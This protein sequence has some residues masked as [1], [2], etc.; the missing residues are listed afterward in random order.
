MCYASRLYQFCF[1]P[2]KMKSARE[3]IFSVSSGVENILLAHFSLNCMRYS[4]VFGRFSDFI[5]G[6]NFVFL[7]QNF[8]ILDFWKFAGKLCSFFSGNDFFFLGMDYF[9]FFWHNFVFSGSFQVF[10]SGRFKTSR[11]E[12]FNF[13]GR[14]FFTGKKILGSRKEICSI[15]KCRYE[16]LT[17][18]T[19]RPDCDF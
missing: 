6:W 19:I 15:V 16:K 13:S 2:E 11:A 1:L 18:E 17:L 3:T 8:R 4:E 9:F 5:L 10:F 7:G 12:S 14:I